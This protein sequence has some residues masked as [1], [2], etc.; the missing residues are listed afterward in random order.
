MK[1]DKIKLF[2]SL[3]LPGSK[4]KKKIIQTC[5]TTKND[6]FLYCKICH[7]TNKKKDKTGLTFKI[8][9]KKKRNK[10]RE[11]KNK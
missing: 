9:N 5:E 11:R 10:E 8:L 2:K 4:Q 1:K 3:H 6:K 7:T